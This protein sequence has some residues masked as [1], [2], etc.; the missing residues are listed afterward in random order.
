LYMT[1]IDYSLSDIIFK[2]RGVM[3]GLF[4]SSL[5]DTDSLNSTLL[6]YSL[7]FEV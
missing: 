6:D 2:V 1:D 5:P 7:E 3:T 4:G